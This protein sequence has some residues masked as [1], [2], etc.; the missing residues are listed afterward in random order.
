M[1]E[2]NAESFRGLVQSLLEDTRDLLRAELA[3]AKA[4]IREEVQL[5]RSVEK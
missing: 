4:E 2:Q 3:L 5:A 1:A